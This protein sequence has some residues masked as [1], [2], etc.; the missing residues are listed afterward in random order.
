[1]A[2]PL[3]FEEL[4]DLL[5]EEHR[6][7]RRLLE[8]VLA[9][10]GQA[11]PGEIL[12]SL[13][14]CLRQHVADEEARVL[15]LLIDVHGHQG[16]SEAIRVFQ[17]HRLIHE[18]VKELRASPLPSSS[19]AAKKAELRKLLE[20]HFAEEEGSIFPLALQAYQEASK[21]G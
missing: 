5:L 11:G 8:E 9:E 15:R 18:L 1:M 3:E 6:E 7:I 10:A 12:A 19:M 14:D 4:V 13:D 2:R 20:D 16:A 17:Q 21:E